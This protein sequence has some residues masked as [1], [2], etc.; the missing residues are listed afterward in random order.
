METKI[1]AYFKKAKRFDDAVIIN[2]KSYTMSFYDMRGY[3]VQY[4]SDH[5]NITK[6]EIETPLGRYDDLGRL[7]SACF[8]NLKI[9]I[10]DKSN[11]PTK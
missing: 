11:T 6:I 4:I 8:N 7:N 10:Y 1:A 5:D 9:T 2:K 3:S